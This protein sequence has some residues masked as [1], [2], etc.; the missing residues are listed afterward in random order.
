VF[1]LVLFLSDGKVSEVPVVRGAG[2]GVVAVR[3]ARNPK[4][5]RWA[6][7]DAAWTQVGGCSGPPDSS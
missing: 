5:V 2:V 3:I 7:F 1:Y 6:V 4:I